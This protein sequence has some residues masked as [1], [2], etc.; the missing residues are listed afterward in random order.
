ME[1]GIMPIKFIIKTRRLLY[2]WHILQRNKEELIARFYE[3]Q[4]YSPSDGDWV[5]QIKRDMDE[6]KLN[7]KE[8]EIKSMSHSQFKKIVKQKV[9]KLAISNLEAKKKQNTRK[10]EIKS[11]KPQEYI[12]SK[13]LSIT[14]VQNLFKIRNNM[15]DVKENFKSNQ[16]NILCKL[17]LLFSENQQHL[18]HCPKIKGKLNGAVNFESLDLEMA[19]QSIESQ[20]KIAKNYTIILNARKDILSQNIGNQ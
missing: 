8:E 11:F 6:I 7:L 5:H 19:Y 18:I 10:V 12:L 13:N 15:I 16:E 3:V 2:Y 4:K 17:C 20:E 1:C 9:T 14:E